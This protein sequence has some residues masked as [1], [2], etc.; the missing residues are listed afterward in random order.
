MNLTAD[1]AAALERI[2]ARDQTEAVCKALRLAAGIWRHIDSDGQLT[3][4]KPSGAVVEIHI[5]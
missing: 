5:V 4:L 3:V 2:P 1:A